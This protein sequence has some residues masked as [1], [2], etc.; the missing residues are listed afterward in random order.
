[1]TLIKH[2]VFNI[3]IVILLV[4]IVRKVIIFF[5]LLCSILFINE[6][7]AFNL[8]RYRILKNNLVEIFNKNNELSFL[9]KLDTIN[10]L[11]NNSITYKDDIESHYVTDYWATPIETMINGYGD[12][13][14][15]AIMK[16]YSLLKLNIPHDRLALIYSKANILNKIQAHMV[17]GVYMDGHASPLIL[18][19][20]TNEIRFA[21]ER[22]DL[23]LIYQFN[24]IGLW[25]KNENDGYWKYPAHGLHKWKSVL[26]KMDNSPNYLFK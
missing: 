13:E 12:C 3:D 4:I 5:C 10:T 19:N 14:D 6:A 8:S 22:K 1:M 9:D 21:S 17:L 7:L 24:D 18:D 2:Y 26:D 16:Y 15:F 25:I 11:F 23:E 20:L